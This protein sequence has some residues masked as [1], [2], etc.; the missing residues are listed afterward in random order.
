MMKRTIVVIILSICF[1]SSSALGL[2]LDISNTESTDLVDVITSP[3]NNGATLYKFVSKGDNVFFDTLMDGDSYVL[4]KWY[5][6]GKVVEMLAIPPR[7]RLVKS[8]YPQPKRRLLR[9]D[10]KKYNFNRCASGVWTE[11]EG[12]RFMEEWYTYALRHVDLDLNNFFVEFG[13]TI[14]EDYTRIYPRSN[15]FVDNI[16]KGATLITSSIEHMGLLFVELRYPRPGKDS[17]MDI[18]YKNWED[19]EVMFS[20]VWII[21]DWVPQNFLY[22]GMLDSG[23]KYASVKK[24]EQDNSNMIQ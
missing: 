21:G 2:V 16:R 6:G 17:V 11:I 18:I 8:I 19:E 12:S 4:Q 24:P 1:C 14:L 15:V 5:I 3:G 9:G 22:S 7:I 23:S 10:K 20:L 13:E